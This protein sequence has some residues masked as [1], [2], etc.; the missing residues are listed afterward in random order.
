MIQSLLTKETPEIIRF[1]RN[2]DSPVSYTH[3]DVYKRQI[4]IPKEICSV[5]LTPEDKETLRKGQAVYLENMINRKR[6]V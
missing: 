2:I 1:F 5:Q 3:L 6:C 4:Y